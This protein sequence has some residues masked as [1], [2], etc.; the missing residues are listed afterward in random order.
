MS[1]WR[2]SCLL[3]VTLGAA[4]TKPNPQS[5]LDGT[6]TDPAFP[7]C[8]LDGALAGEDQTCI[9]VACTADEF[10]ACRGDR[11][12]TCNSTGT[13]YDLVQCPRGCDEGTGCRVCEPNET[14]C[15]NGK[16]Q[17]CDATGAVVASES[18]TLGC[19]EDQPRCREIEPSNGLAPFMSMAATGPDVVLEN[20][21]I[22]VPSGEIT[23]SSGQ[24]IIAS[25]IVPAPPGGVRIQVFPVRSL[26]IVGSLQIRG[27][28]ADDVPAVAF[29]VHGDVRVDGSIQL[30][31]SDSGDFSVT[32]PPGSII[33]GP[34][35]GAVGTFDAN[36]QPAWGA[37][38]GGGG[39]ATQGGAGG[40]NWKWPGSSGGT[41]FPNPDLQPL[42]GGCR[43][44]GHSSQ[45]PSHGG[46]AIQITSRSSIRL[47][48][49]TTILAN[50]GFG[51]VGESPAGEIPGF[52][53]MPKGGGSGGGILLEAPN[54]MFEAGVMIT[55]NGGGGASGDG[56]PGSPTTSAL[57]SSGGTCSASPS[58]CTNGGDGGSSAGPGRTAA[59]IATTGLQEV[60]TGAGGGSVGHIRIN[61]RDGSYTKANDTQES[62]P[63]STAAIGTR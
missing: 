51:F 17:T 12:I 15:E 41:A 10:V 56:A 21:T 14:V 25:Q 7:F 1:W 57:P 37:G 5:C 45:P 29:L 44:G 26:T 34:C 38:G 55:A 2:V 43:G 35:V 18:C 4:C 59:S 28:Q 16:V 30:N 23:S 33:S 36:G 58:I 53:A 8:D 49:N 54:V 42:R 3:V 19:F 46:G 48:P 22:L 47:G 6:C 40:S 27:S 60:Y 13:D 32:S 31:G 52:E 50:G 39:G 11:A 24:V 61:T 63:P 9:A 20:A 62:P